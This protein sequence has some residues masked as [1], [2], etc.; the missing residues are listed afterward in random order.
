MGLAWL[1]KTDYSYHGILLIA[2][3]Y[4]FRFIRC[5]RQSQAA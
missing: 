2:I 4:F 1:L 3:L 5:C